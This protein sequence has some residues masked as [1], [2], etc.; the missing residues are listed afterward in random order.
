MLPK[1]R[2]FFLS[3]ILLTSVGC[4]KQLESKPNSTVLVPTTPA[5]LQGLLNNPDV[6]GYGHTLGLLSAN[7]FY[8]TTSYYSDMLSASEQNAYVWKNTIFDSTEVPPDWAKAYEQVYNANVAL[9]RIAFL[10]SNT[11][12]DRDLNKIKGDALFKRTLSF[13]HLTQ[14]F[15][16]AYDAASASTDLGIPLKLKTDADEAIYRPSLQA[17]YDK[18]LSDLNEAK[19]VLP[20]LP[21][22]VRR[23]QASQVAASALLAR[24]YLCMANWQQSAIAAEFVLQHYDSVINYNSVNSSLEVPFEAD[25]REVIYQL[26][27]PDQ[28]NQNALVAGLTVSVSGANVDTNLI[29]LYEPQDLR[30]SLFFHKRTSKTWA[31]RPTLTGTCTPFEGISISEVYLTLAESYA[32]LGKSDAALLYLNKLLVNRYKTGQVPPLPS[33]TDAETV[34]E[35]ILNERQREL[36][37]RGLKWVDIKR[38]NKQNRRI[39]QQRIVNGQV[40]TISPNDLRYALPL[41]AQTVKKYQLEPNPR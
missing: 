5:E 18:M 37:F 15:A 2:L 17:C 12:E 27:A 9:E 30:L 31:L 21:D 13:F 25:N 36:P 14:L 33:S 22:P 38:Q 29:S 4:K 19:E 35:Q 28:S 1:Y 7:E 24:I 39:T 20:I 10:T 32:R 3:I 6:F 23:N 41:P 34:L 16:P 40:Y 8:F 26:K 11:N